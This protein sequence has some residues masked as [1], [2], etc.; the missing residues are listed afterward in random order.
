LLPPPDNIS[1][2]KPIIFIG[3]RLPVETTLSV[4]ARE[5]YADLFSAEDINRLPAKEWAG[6]AE[7]VAAMLK[8]I[9]VDTVRNIG[10]YDFR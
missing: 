2:R 6:E 3:A 1:V 5:K 7:S 8:R 4:E 9:G 10:R